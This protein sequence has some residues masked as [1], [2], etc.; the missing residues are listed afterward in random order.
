VLVEDTPELPVDSLRADDRDVQGLRTSERGSALSAADALRTALRLG[1]GALVVGE[2]RGE[3]ARVL[4]EAMRVGA[5]S[6]AVLGTIH[7]DGARSVRERVVEDLG[8]SASSFAATDCVVTCRRVT[9]DGSVERRVARVEEVVGAGEDARFE[10]LYRLDDDGRL[11]P[12][13]RV[14]RGNSALVAALA[15][16]TEDYAAVREALAE[17]ESL[18]AERARTGRLDPGAWSA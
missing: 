9:V 14:A 17:R 4:Y 1:E 2:V 18:L 15:T 13:G 10:A 11:R 6:D 7:G 8:V 16:P 5:S 12:T 3:E